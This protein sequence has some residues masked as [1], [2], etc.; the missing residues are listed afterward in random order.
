M[1]G[2]PIVT[3]YVSPEQYPF[4]FHKGRLCQHSSFFEKEFH[5]SFEEATTG[6]MYLD[7]DGIGEFKLFEEWLYSEKFS[8]LKDS[9]DPSLLLVKVFCFVE[10]VG[11]AN[12]QN[13]TLD[14]IRD[15]ATEQHVSL[16]TPSTNYETYAKPQMLRGFCPATDFRPPRTK[17]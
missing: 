13:A 3:L 5:G 8:Y 17:Q 15:G 12:L 9:D 10:K 1:R 11:I 6:G 7:E 4:R 14:A 16:T 2:I